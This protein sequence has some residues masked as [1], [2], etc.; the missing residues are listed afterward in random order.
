MHKNKPIMKSETVQFQNFNQLIEYRIGTSTQD[1]FD[2]IDSAQPEDLWFHVKGQSS[3]HIVAMISAYPP[4]TFSKK[5]LHSIVKKGAL[6]CKQHSR[7]KSDPS[8]EIDYT[9]I[10]N[11]QKTKIAG[12]VIL[13]KT[14]SVIAI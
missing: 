9:R 2:V 3:C 13:R 4:K 11:V 5:E 10:E 7:Y 6:I 14:P 1:N 12:T 8:V